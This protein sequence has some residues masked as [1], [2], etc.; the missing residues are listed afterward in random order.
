MIQGIVFPVLMMQVMDCF[1]KTVSIQ[2]KKDYYFFKF[3]QVNL[4][5]KNRQR[6]SFDL[7]LGHQG[8]FSGKKK[9]LLIGFSVQSCGKEIC[10]DQFSSC[11]N[12]LAITI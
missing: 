3:T 5:T 7:I 2:K 10:E 8:F 1:E 6:S 9:T 12:I 11:A 4:G